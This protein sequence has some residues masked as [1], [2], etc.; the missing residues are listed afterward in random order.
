VR[1]GDEGIELAF[2]LEVLVEIPRPD[3]MA[4]PDVQSEHR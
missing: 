2:I 1:D 3:D 4:G